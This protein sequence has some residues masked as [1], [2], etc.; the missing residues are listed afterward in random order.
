[1]IAAH[2]M[3]SNKQKAGQ[4][5]RPFQRAEESVVYEGD[6]NPNIVWTLETVPEN[7]KKRLD[8]L[9]INGRIETIQ[10]TTC[11]NKIWNT[12]FKTVFGLICPIFENKNRDKCKSS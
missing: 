1:M 11:R 6:N 10:S 12:F 3:K 8:Q 9:D 5:P 7:L 4:I 2:R